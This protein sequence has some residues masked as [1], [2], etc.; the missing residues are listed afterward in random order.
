M[1]SSD[2][3]VWFDIS[4][5]IGWNSALNYRVVFSRVHS[6]K[7][8]TRF[9]N[10]KNNKTNSKRNEHAKVFVFTFLVNSWWCL[11]R[12]KT[13]CLCTN[14]LFCKPSKQ[15]HHFSI[16]SLHILI[17]KYFALH[18][19]LNLNLSAKDI[20]FRNVHEMY[21][22]YANK[23]ILLLHLMHKIELKHEKWVHIQIIVIG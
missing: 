4:A 6:Q 10:V 17:I 9:Q 1:I 22:I 5:L 2:I 7:K 23:I 8:V 16:H 20:F 3:S 13:T 11:Q 18:A 12:I 19:C 15:L 14:T 21:T